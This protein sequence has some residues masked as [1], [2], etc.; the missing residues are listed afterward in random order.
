MKFV[1][2]VEGATEKKGIASF[3]KKYLGSQLSQPVGIQLVDMGG[4]GDFKKKVRRKT[5]MHINGPDR[6]Q[7]IAVIGLLDLYGPQFSNFYPADQ[8]FARQRYEWGV[9][10]FKRKVN[11]SNFRMF[12]AV[13]E[14]EAWILSQPKVLPNSV[15]KLIPQG[16]QPPEEIDF[17]K[18]PSKLLG[19]LYRR[20][21]RSRGYKKVTD[22]SELFS[23]LDPKEAYKMCPYLK[24]MLDGMLALAQGAGL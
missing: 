20:A 17:D 3:L 5:E 13:H 11:N 21:F 15:R 22:G 23:R 1:L 7:L 6:D 9:N 4:Y 19:E 8:T 14:F 12:F 16:L 24:R 10:Y 2:L 18:P